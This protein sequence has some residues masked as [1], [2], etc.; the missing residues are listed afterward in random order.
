MSITSDIL[1]GHTEAI[2]L[3]HL[4]EQDSYGYQINKDIMKKTDNKYELKEATLYSAFRRLEQAGYIHTYWGDETV[5]ARR[6]YYAITEDGR[7]AYQSYKR[8]WEEAK[9][10]ID[11]LLK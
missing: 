9:K 1:R 7:H 4:L 10:I 3:S 11:G 8:D 2:I 6:R 5:G